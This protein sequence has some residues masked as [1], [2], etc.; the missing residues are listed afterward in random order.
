MLPGV[1]AVQRYGCN[2]PDFP[3]CKQPAGKHCVNKRG[4]QVPPHPKRWNLGT[5]YADAW[6]QQQEKIDELEKAVDLRDSTISTLTA[7]LKTIT[8]ER[9]ALQARVTEL[10]TPPEPE[11]VPEPVAVTRYGACPQKGGESLAAA[12]TV[13]DKYGPGSAIRQ[14]LGTGVAQRPANASIVH[15]SWKPSL[16]QIT[17]SWVKS[18]TQNLRPGDCVEVWHEGNKKVSDGTLTL[19]DITK[20][21]NT[22][23]DIVKKVRPDLRVANTITGWAADPKSGD[24]LSRWVGEVKADVLGIDCDG[25]RPTKLPYTNYE[26]ETKA[27]LA[28]IEKYKANG[29]RWFAAPEFGCPRIPT[30]DPDGTIRA[31]YHDHYADLWAATGKFLYACLYEY[32]SSPNYSLTTPAEIAGWRKHSAK[33]S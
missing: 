19:D 2:D 5:G 21:K 10:E 25:I 4:K 22:F 13:I 24:D 32:D 27:A 3:A 15:I 16:A 28:L 20:R 12:Q 7:G 1:P 30:A 18:V 8:L 23:Y 9:N 31:A 26:D 33:E 6:D 17:E 11:P 14:F 29:Y